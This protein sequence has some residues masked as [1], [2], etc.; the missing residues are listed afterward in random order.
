MFF[1]KTKRVGTNF[2]CG[3]KKFYKAGAMAEKVLLQNPPSQNSLVILYSLVNAVFKYV[4]LI[5]L[6]ILFLEAW[7]R[8]F[9]RTTAGIL[10]KLSGKQNK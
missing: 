1:Q 2:I 7:Q 3:G 9:Q 6:S 10:L 8:V 5:L 4:I